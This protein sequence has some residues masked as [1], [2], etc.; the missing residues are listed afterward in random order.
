M[1]EQ[2]QP[3]VASHRAEALRRAGNSLAK[4]AP[5]QFSRRATMGSVCTRKKNC[6]NFYW[7]FRTPA[8]NLLS[9]RGIH[10]SK[11]SYEGT[12]NEPLD[13][14]GGRFPS[15]TCGERGRRGNCTIGRLAAVRRT[16]AFDGARAIE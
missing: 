10:G 1:N 2:L 6:G 15:E 13:K 11:F 16:S 8:L 5:R 12:R 9:S 3:S 14:R 7:L 4:C